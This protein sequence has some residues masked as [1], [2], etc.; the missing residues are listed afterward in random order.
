MGSLHALQEFAEGRADVAGF[1]VPIGAPRRP[2]TARRSC[3]GLRA[4]RDRLIRFVDR[5]QGL[6]LPRGNPAQ[7]KNLRDVASQRLRFVNRQRGSGT[8]L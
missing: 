3:A 7:V 4:R 2:G 1:H 8:R 5:E 6:I